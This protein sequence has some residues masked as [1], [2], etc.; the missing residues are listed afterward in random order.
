MGVHHDRL[1]FV[2]HVVPARRTAPETVSFSGSDGR[3]LSA[4]FLVWDAFEL[5]GDARNCIR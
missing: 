2:R 3:G 1:S 5:G 4:R